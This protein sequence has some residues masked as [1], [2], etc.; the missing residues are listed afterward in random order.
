MYAIGIDIGTTSICGI[1]LDTDSGAVVKSRTEASDAF[2]ATPNS[3][4]KIQDTGKVIG[5]AL[6]ILESFADYPAAVIG[7]TGQ[8]HGIVYVD[9]KGRAVSPLYT[10]QDNRGN[11][12]YGDTTYACH[13]GSFSGYGNVTD[14]YNRVNH[15]RP[16]SAVS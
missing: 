15:L 3:W 12:P 5:L 13:L 8:M 14:F 11:L 16:D 9:E 1:V 2:I 7:L 10:W 6:E 4:E